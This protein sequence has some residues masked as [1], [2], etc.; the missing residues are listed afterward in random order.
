M[1]KTR[2]DDLYGYE[3]FHPV[4]VLGFWL[5]DLIDLAAQR[6]FLDPPPSGVTLTR[7]EEEAE[8]GPIDSTRDWIPWLERR[9]MA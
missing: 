7:E 3:Y 1:N 4:H 2:D 5:W 6:R 9:Q 8:Y